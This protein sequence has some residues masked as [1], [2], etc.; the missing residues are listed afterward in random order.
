MVP[1]RAQ[2]FMHVRA[3]QDLVTRTLCRPRRQQCHLPPAALRCGLDGRRTR[4]RDRVFRARPEH[5]HLQL[6]DGS[7]AARG[8]SHRLPEAPP[9]GEPCHWRGRPVGDSEGGCR[10]A[11]PLATFITRLEQDLNVGHTNH[12]LGP[13]LGGA[14]DVAKLET[15]ILVTSQKTRKCTYCF[16]NILHS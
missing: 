10:S 3:K 8:S 6:W 11:D 7:G 16:P 15:P 1:D 5:V 13:M 9:G 12:Y 2:V 4:R 14:S